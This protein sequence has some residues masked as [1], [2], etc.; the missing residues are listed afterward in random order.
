M[1]RE[2]V[3]T[4]MQMTRPPGPRATIPPS[5]GFRAMTVALVSAAAML[6]HS[7]SALAA[8]PRSEGFELHGDPAAGRVV[9]ERHCATCHGPDGT[10]D[11]REGQAFD[12]GP[13]DF[14]RLEPDAERFYRATRDGGMA[15]GLSAAMP[16]FRHT[17]SEQE[18]H[19]VVAHLIRLA[20]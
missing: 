5:P 9:Y 2:R 14:T 7:A 16:A 10:G 17:L 1:L 20:R 19:D 12:P 8:E 18:I 3:H 6:V 4:P 15:V 13:S 11:G